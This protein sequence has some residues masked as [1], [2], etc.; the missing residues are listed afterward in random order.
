MSVNPI[1]NTRTKHVE[2]DFQFVRD[3]VADKSLEIFFILRLDQLADVLTKPLV[4]TR[5]QRLCFKLKVPP[6]DLAGGY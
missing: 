5:F 1:F 4:S 6:V 3:R 2:I